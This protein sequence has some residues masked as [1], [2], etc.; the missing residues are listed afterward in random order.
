MK[1]LKEILHN[2]SIKKIIGDINILIGD[3]IFD[4]HKLSSDSLF[5]AIKGSSF[6]SHNYIDKAISLGASAI[7]CQSIPKNINSEIVYIKV[8]NT[9]LAL[10]IC[11]ANFFNNPSKKIKLVGI[12]G[13]N[14]KTSIATLL[15]HLFESLNIKTGLISTIENR[16]NKD[17][18]PSKLTTPDPYE[19]NF[20]LSK[21]VANQCEVCFMEV[22][23]HGISQH[24]IEGLNFICGVFSNISRDHLDYHKDFDEYVLTK[25]KFFDLLNKESIAIVNHD[26]RYSET[27]LADNIS[28]KKFYGLHP[29]YDYYGKVIHNTLDGLHLMINNC[30]F[31]SQI[32]GLFNAYN[33]LAIYAVATELGV[34]KIALHSVF[35]SLQAVPGRFNI[36]KSKKGI[37]GIVD[38]AHSPDALEKVFSTVNDLRN[39]DQQV[40]SILG[41][42]GNRDVGKRPIMGKIAYLNSNVSIFTSDNPRYESPDRIISDMKSQI[43]IENNRKLFCI[44]DRAEA[45]LKATVLAQKGDVILILGKGHEDYQEIAGEKYPFDDHKILTKI[46]Q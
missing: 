36:I 20:L 38:Y 26:D 8:K 15:F 22:S 46:L 45:I 11:C 3:V 35:N 29:S 40:I 25:K 39:D 28:K 6:D 32:T 12:T 13:T 19:I 44:K 31:R 16:V 23:S 30:E 2:V 14:G 1:V 9:R 18:F 34:N 7:L 24:R 42:G 43:V 4:T 21:M 10:A 17:I 37:I 41:C 5:I 27:M 33:L